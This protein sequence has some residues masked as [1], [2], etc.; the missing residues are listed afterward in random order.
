MK[1]IRVHEYGE[2]RVNKD[3][4]TAGIV[5]VL[6]IIATVLFLI[7]GAVYESVLGS[8]DYLE[9]AYPDRGTVTLGVLLEFVCVLAIPLIGVFLFPVLKRYNEALALAYVVFRSLEAVF[10][11]GIEAKLLSLIDV[12]QDYA[13][14]G[15]ADASLFQAVGDGIQSEIDWAFDIYVLVFAVGA[16]ILYSLLHSS[17][18]VPRFVS[19]W[20]FVAAAWLLA[21]VVL[22]MFDAFSGTST[23]LVEGIFATPIAVNEM[24]LALWLIV[25]G[26]DRTA[27]SAEADNSPA[28]PRQ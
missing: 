18:L 25:K 7:G 21:G 26:F 4:R 1:A 19:I 3:R 12:S 6:F 17:R 10:L 13:D 24:V 20:G 27:V 11:I 5:G 15:G 14:S 8:S 23:S 2:E 9:S 22:V 16:L 28:T